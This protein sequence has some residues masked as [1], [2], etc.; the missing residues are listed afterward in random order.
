MA[1]GARFSDDT[2]CTLTAGYGKKANYCSG[3][4]G[5]TIRNRN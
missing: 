4:R 5:I 3:S 1:G 2:T